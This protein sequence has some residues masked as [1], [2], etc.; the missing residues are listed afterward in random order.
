[1]LGAGL[2]RVGNLDDCKKQKPEMERRE[3]KTGKAHDEFPTFR[4]LM[5]LITRYILS[6]YLDGKSDAN[7]NLFP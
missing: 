7:L 2:T 5:E 3:E 4:L 6:I 1:M